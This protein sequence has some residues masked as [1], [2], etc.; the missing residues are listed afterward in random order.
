VARLYAKRWTIEKMFLELTTALVCEIDT[1]GYPRA[2]LFGFCLALVAYNVVSL[3]QAA[4]RRVHG[5]QKVE[6]ELSWYYVCV[7]VGKVYQGMMIALPAECWKVFR[8]MSDRDFA[9][10]LKQ[11]A[12]NTDLARFRKHPRGPKKPP[13]KK[14]N[15]SKR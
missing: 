12:E 13:P 14:S 10:F 8:Q 6:E 15:G 9:R 1:L 7:H 2:A 5:H 11:L 4:L 3:T